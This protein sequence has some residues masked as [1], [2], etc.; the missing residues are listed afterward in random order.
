MKP[1]KFNN[2]GVNPLDLSVGLAT[3]LNHFDDDRGRYIDL[4]S[5][6]GITPGVG[7][8]YDIHLCIRTQGRLG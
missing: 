7:S 1:I 8:L 3:Q 5:I 4:S 2:R 6:T